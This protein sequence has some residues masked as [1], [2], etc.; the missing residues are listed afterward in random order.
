MHVLREFSQELGE[1]GWI[2]QNYDP[3]HLL[4]C[5]GWQRNATSPARR[6]D[7]NELRTR[8]VSFKVFPDE[9]LQR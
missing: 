2:F 4:H 9:E 8:E 6:S 3:R 7:G 1:G 5:V